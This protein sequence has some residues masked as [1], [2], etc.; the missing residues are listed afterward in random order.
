[1]DLENIKT[2]QDRFLNLS[3]VFEIESFLTGWF[4]GA[5][6]KTVLLGNLEDFVA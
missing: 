6:A 4:N 1:M 3:G 2:V 5:D